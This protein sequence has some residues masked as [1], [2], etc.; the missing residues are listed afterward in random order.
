MPTIDPAVIKCE[1]EKAFRKLVISKDK[2]AGINGCV[3]LITAKIL[4]F[5]QLTPNRFLINQEQTSNEL[6]IYEAKLQE[7]SVLIDGFNQSTVAVL[8]DVDPGNIFRKTL[9]IVKNGVTLARKRLS[10]K[11]I[12]PSRKKNGRPPKKQTADI[13]NTLYDQYQSL[14]GKKPI[15]SFN[16][17]TRKGSGL[18]PFSELVQDILTIGNLRSSAAYASRTVCQR[19]SEKK[20]NEKTSH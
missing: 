7:L 11:K 14:T 1:V 19:K 6:D 3:T 2:E 18:S 17:R 16:M 4:T 5:N 9:G 15:H 12:A 13:A 10:T 20:S 8:D